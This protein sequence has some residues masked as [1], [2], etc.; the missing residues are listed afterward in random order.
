[1][2]HSMRSLLA[3]II[4]ISGCVFESA[5]E[6]VFQPA[7]QAEEPI[8]PKSAKKD[9]P[10]L[11]LSRET[12]YITAPL[13][14]DGDVDYAAGLSELLGKGVTPESNANVLLI[15]AVGPGSGERPAE[16]HKRLA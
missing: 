5:Y 7:L 10:R 14:K 9:A 4:V 12:T 6:R 15:K 16:Y 8:L 13:D 3:S 2:R 11:K 1:M